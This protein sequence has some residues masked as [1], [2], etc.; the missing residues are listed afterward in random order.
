MKTILIW[1]KKIFSGYRIIWFSSKTRGSVWASSFLLGVAIIIF[2]YFSYV[3]INYHLYKKK[4]FKDTIAH[5]D[6]I[7]VEEKEKFE[8]IISLATSIYTNEKSYKEEILKITTNYFGHFSPEVIKKNKILREAVERI[9]N[10][11][12]DFAKIDIEE[13]LL[14][15]LNVHHF[16]NNLNLSLDVKKNFFR[17]IPVHWPIINHQ[18]YTTSHFGP[19]YSPFTKSMKMHEGVD[20]VSAPGTPIVAAADGIVYKATE[21]KGYGKVVMIRHKYGFITVYAHNKEILVKEGRRVKQGQ[22]IAKL[23]NSGRSTGYHLHFEIRINNK[24]IDPWNYIVN[25]AP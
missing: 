20:I 7:T 23:G 25:S 9:E 22:S 19:R 3:V 24:A 2:I 17:D 6:A 21:H 11:S 15:L 12:N 1:L 5:C 10:Q 16:L 8:N 4:E 13:S 14:L 18:G